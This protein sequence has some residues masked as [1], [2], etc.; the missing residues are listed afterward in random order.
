[1]I[2]RIKGKLEQIND[3]YALVE[4]HGVYYEVLLPSGL[5]QR[6]K[7][8]GVI[9]GEIEFET[10]YY[11]EAGDRKANHYPKMVG[12]TNPIDR[13]FFSLFLQVP[14]LGVKKALKSLVLPV[15]DIASAIELK[16][17]ARLKQLPGVGTRLADMI[18]AE[19]CG[20]TAKF[21]LAR[22]SEPL[23]AKDTTPPPFADEA[24]EVLMQLQYT[25]AEA[26]EMIETALKAEPKISKAEDLISVVFRSGLV[27]TGGR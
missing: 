24:L 21:A 23:A 9:G 2:S 17:T 19:L 10:I 8:S 15:R 5:A 13:E 25:R 6:L 11:I 20:K 22:S 1:M 4:N 3:Q 18:V 7:D 14:G 16:D 26:K 27:G 12:F